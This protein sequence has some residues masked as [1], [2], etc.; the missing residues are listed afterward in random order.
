MNEY[1]AIEVTPA[2]KRAPFDRGFSLV[3]ML[4]VI[5]V[6]GIL[7]T[8]AVFAVRGT[9][10]NAESQACQSELKSLNTMV[11]AHFVRTGERTIAPTGVTDDRFEIT[12]V[13]A[14]IMRSVS[15]NYHIDADG[16]V[17]PVAGT[18]CD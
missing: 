1:D 16:E 10:S 12:L 11:E 18:I 3:E 6:L 7:A 2:V 9:T 5:V 13:D 8:V 15:A 17:T 4:I 14:Q